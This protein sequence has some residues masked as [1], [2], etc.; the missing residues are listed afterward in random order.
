MSGTK[1]GSGK[2]IPHAIIPE[3]DQSRQDS[4]EGSS[5][6]ESKESWRV[7]KDC[8][9]GSYRA[10]HSQ[11]FG[12]EPSFIVSATPLSKQARR[13]ARYAARNDINAAN[14]VV[15][16]GDSDAG[17]VG[18]MFS[19]EF[20]PR[21][22]A[23]VAGWHF[24]SEF[25]DASN[26]SDVSGS[27]ELVFINCDLVGIDFRKGDRA[28]SLGFKRQAE[29]ADAGKEV[30]MRGGVHCRIRNAHVPA[31]SDGFPSIR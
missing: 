31:P 20:A 19:V 17:T 21:F 1:R 2:Y 5:I 24:I 13:L 30:K 6:F 8:E 14:L 3:R 25:S 4:V 15:K 29:S 26:V 18:P 11:G 10:N 23:T 16:L 28:E 22:I 27:G 12:P 9:A 7:L